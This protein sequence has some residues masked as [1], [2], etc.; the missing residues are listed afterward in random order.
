MAHDDHGRA[1]EP[2][3]L[4]DAAARMRE[5]IRQS[6]HADLD[7]SSRRTEEMLPVTA[8]QEEPG[9][10]PRATQTCPGCGGSGS[11]PF[12]GTCGACSGRGEIGSD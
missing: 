8:G 10:R 12:G 11:S 1:T 3:E 4:A 7:A 5:E 2:G 9:S 6:L